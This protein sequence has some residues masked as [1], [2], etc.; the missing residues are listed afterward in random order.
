VPTPPIAVA[1]NDH[2]SYDPVMRWALAAALLL[3]GCA[4]YPGSPCAPAVYAAPAVVPVYGADQARD[5]H[6]D[7]AAVTTTG[8][9]TSARRGMIAVP[10]PASAR[11]R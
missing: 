3:G 7:R 4:A 5:A 8:N 9:L 6:V 2:A 1:R 10:Q 11:C